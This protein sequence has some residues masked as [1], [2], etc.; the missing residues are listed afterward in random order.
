MTGGDFEAWLIKYMAFRQKAN[1]VTDQPIPTDLVLLHQE[2]QE[3][4]ALYSKAESFRADAEFF[5]RQSIEN[6]QAKRARIV[7]ALEDTA[8][9]CRVI[10]SRAMKVAQQVKI[11]DGQ[12][13]GR[14]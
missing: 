8:G 13:P 7:W 6:K 12:A 4:E 11:Q 5:N 3:L 2:A 9:R 1:A 10:A 14:R